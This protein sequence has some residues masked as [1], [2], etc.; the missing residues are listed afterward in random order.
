MLDNMIVPEIMRPMVNA[1]I[2]KM[3]GVSRYAKVDDTLVGQPGDSV[4]IPTWEYIGMAGEVAEGEAAPEAT[5]KA[6]TKKIKI[7]TA[8]KTVM[9]TDE[10]RKVAYGDPLGQVERQLALSI[11][12]KVES[13]CMDEFYTATRKVGDGAE[14]ISFKGLVK[15]ATAIRG[16][17]DKVLFINPA[18]E[19]DLLS[20]DKFLESDR[21]AGQ[22]LVNGAIG[23]A[24]GAQVV[25]S[26][27]VRLV[28]VEKN[29]SGDVEITADN[30]VENQAKCAEALKVGDKVKA[31]AKGKSY[32][33]N[34]II[35]IANST[36]NE[37]E[38]GEPALTIL[39]KEETEIE[40]DRTGKKRIS[41]VTATKYY[42]VGLTNDSKVVLAKFKA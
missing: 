10:M 25:I 11:F 13:D 31:L 4:T 40:V 2:G 30:L 27:L 20:D 23:R 42:G 26:D 33:L 24:A 39:L 9:V 14:A 17:G 35:R 16:K 1:T 5:L 34:P 37:V 29:D 7:K 15:A 32:Y 19:A 28:E 41:E 38:T 18:Q 3:L 21:L 8:A 22:V 6:S 36:D 12:E